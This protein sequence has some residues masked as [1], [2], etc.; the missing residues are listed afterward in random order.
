MHIFVLAETQLKVEDRQNQQE[1]LNEGQTP[2]DLHKLIIFVWPER[3]WKILA[4][5]LWQVV[6]QNIINDLHKVY[7]FLKTDRVVSFL[8][9]YK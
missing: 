8:S 4:S 7:G 6:V 3:T 5:A 9:P 1:L 2:E